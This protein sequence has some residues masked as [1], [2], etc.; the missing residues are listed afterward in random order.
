MATLIKTGAKGDQVIA[1]QNKLT[2]L[3]FAV[4]PDGAFGPATASAVEELQTMFGYD[5]DGIVGD[6]TLKLIDTQIGFGWKVDAEGAVK[7]ALEAQAKKTDKGAL[8][9]A[10]LRRTLKRGLEGADVK[11]A[12]RRLNAL[13][14]QVAVDGK[15]GE[16]TEQAVRKLQQAFGYDVDGILGEATH[17][18]INQQLGYGWKHGSSSAHASS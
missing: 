12:Q 10:A 15:Y 2:Q 14:F 4:N 13:G 5:V 18:L 17:A 9:G 3:G 16:N 6:A 7:R 8:A 1:L 11:Y